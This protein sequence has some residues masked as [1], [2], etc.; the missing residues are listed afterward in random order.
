MI[1]VTPHI[2]PARTIP[3][4][5]STFSSPSV[6]PFF[7]PALFAPTARPREQRARP[8]PRTR[9]PCTAASRTSSSP[10][11]PDPPPPAPPLLPAPNSP[12]PHNRDGPPP[13][14]SPRRRQP[15][16]GRKSQ[17]TAAPF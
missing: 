5:Q 4:P 11:Q 2:D 7:S 15:S 3:N 1:N 9:N 6:H 8:P 14:L 13:R 12:A 17:E 10:L 16:P